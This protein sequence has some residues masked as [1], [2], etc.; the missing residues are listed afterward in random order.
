M[1][2]D[3]LISFYRIAAY[4]LLLGVIHAALT[5]LFF[6][7]F[8]IE[9]MW[10]FGTGLALVFLCLLNIA[11][12][13]LLVPWLLNMTVVANLIGTIHSFLILILLKQPQAYIGLA[14]FVIVLFASCRVRQKVVRTSI[15]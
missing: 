12:S 7:F 13:K 10:F 6:N 1:K 5:P 14:F 11:A 15:V 4:L 3:K 2:N 9:A 8:T